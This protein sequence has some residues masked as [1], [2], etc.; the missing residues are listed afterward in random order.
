VASTRI[1]ARPVV[2]QLC[3]GAK[4]ALAMSQM[5]M[6]GMDM[7]TMPT[8]ATPV[9]SVM[10]CPVVMGL[11]VLSTVLAAW[12]LFTA[13]HDRHR[14]VTLTRLVRV[15]ARLPVVRT[16]AS[17]ALAGGLA[18]ATIVAVDGGTTP[19]LAL[20]LTLTVLLAAISIAATLGSLAIARCIVALC[21]RFIVAIAG[22]IAER[23][24]AARSYR[25]LRRRPFHA[26]LVALVFG[27]GLR[28]PPLPAH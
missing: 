20:A 28:A 5:N 26:T 19:S 12:S 10:I 21:A 9:G 3:G 25:S 4:A 18:I 17:L 8:M 15:L 11:I 23:R 14:V 16:F 2:V 13:W 27:R 24:A 22:A 7:G 6:P 1:C